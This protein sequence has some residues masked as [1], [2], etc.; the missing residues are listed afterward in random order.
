M[1]IAEALEKMKGAAR[2]RH[3]S[4]ATEK[5]YGMWLPSYRKAVR[6]YPEDWWS[7]LDSGPGFDSPEPM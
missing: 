3:F 4:L 1:A 6:S 2:L 5:S 7:P